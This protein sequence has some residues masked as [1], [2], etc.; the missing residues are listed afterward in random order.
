MQVKVE[1]SEQLGDKRHV[2]GSRTDQQWPAEATIVY[3]MSGDLKLT[4]QPNAL[5][6]IVHEAMKEQ[7]RHLLWINVFPSTES[8]LKLTCQWLLAS[9]KGEDA[10]SIKRQVKKDNEFVQHLHILVFLI[11]L[12]LLHDNDAS[13]ITDFCS[14]GHTSFPT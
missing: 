12:V 6:H 10:K 11:L 13:F 2:Q 14:H 5:A 7:T 9:T 8:R 1:L 4:D 3:P